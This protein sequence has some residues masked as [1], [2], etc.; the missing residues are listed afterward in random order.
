MSGVPYRL[1]GWVAVSKKDGKKFLSIV[2]TEI[3][4]EQKVET[5]TE[6]TM[7]DF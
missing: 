7:P 6:A 2:I 5:K 4:P 3:K 1:A